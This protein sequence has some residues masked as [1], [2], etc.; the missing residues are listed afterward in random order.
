MKRL[1]KTIGI[2]IGIVLF[3]NLI[4]ILISKTE[5]T[6]S[7]N[8]IVNRTINSVVSEYVGIGLEE[9]EIEQV[10]II[11]TELPISTRFYYYLQ[12]MHI[13]ATA[14][15]T[16][17]HRMYNISINTS[18]SD[19]ELAE[20]V[21][22]E[23]IH[24]HQ[25]YRGSLHRPSTDIVLWDDVYYELIHIDYY[26]RPWEQEAKWKSKNLQKKIYRKFYQKSLD[27]K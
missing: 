9:L 21:A 6:S 20:V 2:I 18:L 11:L 17:Y 1:L 4:S 14:D 25:Y 15:P 5:N 10:V 8:T 13:R 19:W 26:D 3:F 23:L 27:I 7:K 24:I 12:G 16:Q 22:H